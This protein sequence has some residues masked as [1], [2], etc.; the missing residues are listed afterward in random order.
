MA[1]STHSLLDGPVGRVLWEQSVP[2]AVG[3]VFMLAVNLID[4]YWAAQLG[5]DELAAMSFAFPIIGIVMN[6]SIGLMI[7]TSVAVARVVGAGDLPVAK[8]IAAH[9]IFLGI[10]VVVLVTGLGLATQDATFRALGAPETLLPVIDGYMRIWYFGAA[11]LVV[12]MMLNG[13]LRAHGDAKTPRNMMML[14][15]VFN[16]VLDPLFI[17]GAGPVPAMGLEG[18]ALATAA[19]RAL[20]FVYAGW[21]ALRGGLLDLHLPS[22]S[23]LIDSWTRVL[24]VGVPAAMTNVLGPIATALLTAIVAT[25]GAS[26]VAA[27]G[28]GARVE[29]LLLIAPM[30]LSSGL[31]PFVG[32]NWGAHLEDRVREGFRLS[33]RFC[34]AWGTGALLILLVTAPYIAAV[35][36]DDPEVQQHIVSYLRIVPFG[37]GGYGAM[38]MVSSSFNAMDHALRSTVLSVLRSIVFAVPIAWMGSMVAGI[39]GVFFGL[40]A[41]SLLAALV[42]LR[43]MRMFLDPT[44]PIRLDNAQIDDGGA[45]LVER[46]TPDTQAAMRTLV[47][48]LLALEAV[49]LH[50]V[51]SDAVGFYSGNRQIGHIHPAG[52]MDLALPREIGELLVKQKMLEHHRLHDNAGWYSR[53]LVTS[54]DVRQSQWV[55][56]LAHA[57]FEIWKR[58]VDHEI[59]KQ[60]LAA[61]NLP[62]GA[63]E[64]ITTAAARW[65][66]VTAAPPADA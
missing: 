46:S 59:S 51:R 10:G 55:L 6:V 11:F 7:G 47:D 3:V 31:S 37:Y 54:H 44:Q 27:Y 40:V 18:A 60:E 17:F 29:A 42:G 66:P 12:P 39:E 62:E 30:A 28:I 16:A 57:L 26:A 9:A 65:T 49:E 34:I 35:F 32:Q 64:A 15:A 48:T 8:R 1:E 22:L 43:W 4:T 5:T 58:G 21:I 38:M 41:G 25:F 45:F 63:A 14:S 36:S 20:T 19:A 56:R 23:D 52:H 13:V 61:L 50:Q 2:M 24:Q 53:Q 33:V